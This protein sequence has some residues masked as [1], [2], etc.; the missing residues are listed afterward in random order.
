MFRRLSAPSLSLAGFPVGPSAFGKASQD[1]LLQGGSLWATRMMAWARRFPP[2]ERGPRLKAALNQLQPGLGDKVERTAERIA[3]RDRVLPDKALYRA[4]QFG[5]ADAF[6]RGVLE[7][8]ADARS[9]RTPSTRNFVS[10]T[11]AAGVSGLGQ[12]SPQ[13]TPEQITGDIV[14]GVV[15]SDGVASLVGHA[16][17]VNDTTKSAGDRQLA[18]GLTELGV[19]LGRSVSGA[20]GHP[21]TPSS[22]TPAPI[23]VPPPEPPTPEWVLPAAIGAGVLLVGGVVLF[24]ALK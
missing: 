23:P 15:C 9:G 10:S 7:L 3:A 14:S 4:L 2:P 19:I 5:F 12:S 21:C 8:G 16:A 22:P 18:A 13:R 11:Q 17:G 24:V 6:V 1:T 20:V